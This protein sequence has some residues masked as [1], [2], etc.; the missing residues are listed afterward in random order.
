MLTPP[1]KVGDIIQI[2]EPDYMYGRGSLHLR[3]TEVGATERHADDLW[4]HLYGVDLNA[5]GHGD[6][7]RPRW[8]LVR[9][10]ALVGQPRPAETNP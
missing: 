1:V 4:L 8:A 7:G 2:S 5:A 9:V 6:N 3:V 10:R